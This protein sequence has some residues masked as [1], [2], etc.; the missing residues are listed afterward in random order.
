MGMTGVNALLKALPISGI[1][2]KIIADI[3]G[4][5][6]YEPP[7]GL[8]LPFV[9]PVRIGGQILQLEQGIGRFAAESLVSAAY[10]ETRRRLGTM[11]RPVIYTDKSEECIS[12]PRAAEF[13]RSRGFISGDLYHF[14]SMV[15]DAVCSTRLFKST[16]NR[17]EILTRLVDMPILPPPAAMMVSLDEIPEPAR[18]DSAGG[19]WWPDVP[20]VSFSN[21]RQSIVTSAT[22]LDGLT[23]KRV[24]SHSGMLGDNSKDRLHR[25]LAL[26]Y[27]CAIF[28]SSAFVSY[29]CEVSGFR[30]AEALKTALVSPESY[31][32][33]HQHQWP[34][35]SISVNKL[36]F[37]WPGLIDGEH[38][39]IGIVVVGSGARQAAEEIA[40]SSIG[41]NV[42]IADPSGVSELLCTGCQKICP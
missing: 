40:I 26:H 21:W 20:M 30:S 31:D 14:L 32:Y 36:S 9:N 22:V 34:Y 41:S 35:E 16:C 18:I 10:S 25:W 29:L 5:P 15:T 12:L 6:I 7:A 27:W 13:L 24:Y 37:S 11:D 17:V 1:R 28:P 33:A 23:G 38:K 3:G 8:A 2:A 19:G 42:V 39:T 4:L